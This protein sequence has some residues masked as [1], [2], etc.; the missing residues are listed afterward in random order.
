MS[1]KESNG[2]LL[3]GIGKKF[4]NAI[5]KTRTWVDQEPPDALEQLRQNTVQR[6]KTEEFLIVIAKEIDAVLRE[7]M[8]RKPGG[9][10][11]FPG[12]I[13]VYLSEDDDSQWRGAR[14]AAFEEALQ[15]VTMDVA[16]DLAVD[17]PLSVNSIKIDLKTDATLNKNQVYARGI[18]EE[19]TDTNVSFEK[20]AKAKTP[21]PEI[22]EEKPL[23]IHPIFD[24]SEDTE[25]A[26]E[27]TEFYQEN[28]DTDFQRAIEP[29]KIEVWR[30]GKKE[31]S[32]TFKQRRIVIGR[33][34]QQGKVDVH[35]GDSQKISRTH[36]VL[37]IDEDGKFRLTSESKN[38]TRLAGK[39]L[40][41]GETEQVKFNQTIQ[42]LDFTLKLKKAGESNLSRTNSRTKHIRQ[43]SKTKAKPNAKT[44]RAKAK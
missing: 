8:F 39:S 13:V 37:E 21:V 29:F 42:I 32:Q 38:P 12:E 2:G 27:D 34:S 9:A 10:V 18:W 17:A 15:Q 22:I 28:E 35:L 43:T 41:Q 24:S 11:Y 14:R 16:K 4:W 33:D 31:S 20:F 25:F 23:E 6:H 36:A 44:T 30:D 5:E 19:E 3:R 7:Q 26:A 40:N 1:K